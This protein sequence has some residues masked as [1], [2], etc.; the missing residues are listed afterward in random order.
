VGK[1][2]VASAQLG[3]EGKLAFPMTISFTNGT[4]W[5]FEVPRS[6]RERA[7]DFVARLAG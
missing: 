3:E 2:Q 7:A 6:R 5:D 1:A 4:T